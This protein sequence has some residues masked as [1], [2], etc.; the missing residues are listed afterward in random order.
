[1]RI[2]KREKHFGIHGREMTAEYNGSRQHKKDLANFFNTREGKEKRRKSSK[3][4]KQ[5][6]CRGNPT[7]S[8]IKNLIKES[9]RNLLENHTVVKLEIIKR[10][11]DVYCMT[12]P[13]YGN[14]MLADDNGNG[15]CSSNCHITV[16]LMTIIQQ[17]MPNILRDNK[18]YIVRAPLFE[19]MNSKGEMI[20]GD[21]LSQMEKAH[22]K[23]TSVN[24]MKGLG[25]CT[26]PL[27][28]RVATNPET[29]NLLQLK[30]P[31]AKE[32]TGL[33]NLMGADSATRKKLVR[34][35]SK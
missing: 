9:P 24:R 13:K 8:Y 26:V 2:L 20:A 25:G 35:L 17:T 11:C 5:T 3:I 29:R 33:L 32:V 30:A 28:R 16:L 1:L 22:G 6:N 31:S 7:W 23:L 12:V 4:I 14:F 18:V 27:L 15:I 21:N 10:K 19:A 34:K